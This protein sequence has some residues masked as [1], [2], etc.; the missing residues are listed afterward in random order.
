MTPAQ[1]PASTWNIRQGLR[2]CREM[3]GMS[4]TDLAKA[5]GLEPS[6]V[7][8]FETGQRVPSLGNLIRLADALNVTLDVLCL[9]KT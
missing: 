7:S 3:R 8:H 2:E 9:R 6:A 1:T 5:T 4:Q